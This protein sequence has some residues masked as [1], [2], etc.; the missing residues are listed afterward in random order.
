VTSFAFRS[1][2]EPPHPYFV[3]LHT[4]EAPD[5]DTWSRYVEALAAMIRQA[6]ATIN[7]FAV[8]DGGGPD[9]GQRRELAAAFALDQRGAMTHV[10]T[11]SA[12]TRGIVTAFHWVARA[13]AVAHRPEDFS[14]VC[15]RC[16][17]AVRPVLEDLFLLQRAMVPVHLLAQ[18]EALTRGRSSSGI[19][20]A[21]SSGAG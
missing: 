1:R 18:I 10:F 9:P 12:F 3:L 8:T 14:G 2:A 19:K 20:G 15:E 11:T 21:G 7:I 13:R 16:G 5:A 6:T 17:I 4:A